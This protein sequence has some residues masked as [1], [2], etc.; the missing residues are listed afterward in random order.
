MTFHLNLLNVINKGKERKGEEQ[1]WEGSAT[2]SS[3]GKAGGKEG[4]RKR[5]KKE[6]KIHVAVSGSTQAES[7]P[8]SHPS[9]AFPGNVPEQCPSQFRCRKYSQGTPGHLPPPSGPG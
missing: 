4:K 7:K 6:G 5:Q 3:Q 2:Y 1:E 8:M 9:F